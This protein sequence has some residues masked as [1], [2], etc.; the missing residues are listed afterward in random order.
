MIASTEPFDPGC[1]P[2]AF[3]AFLREIGEA[4]DR[5][6]IVKVKQPGTGKY[7]EF[8]EDG[9]RWQIHDATE[10]DR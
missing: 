10:S 7:I 6:L 9:H 1:P 3:R 5:P 2:H 8:I 4:A